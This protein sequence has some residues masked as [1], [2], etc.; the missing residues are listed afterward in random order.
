[1]PFLTVSKSR[2][3]LAPGGGGQNDNRPKLRFCATLGE[4]PEVEV[5][6]G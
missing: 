4:E 3:R 2:K 1:L 6:L 5:G